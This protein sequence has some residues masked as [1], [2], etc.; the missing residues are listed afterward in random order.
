M[1][2]YL[3]THQ[4][5][6]LGSEAVGVPLF[7]SYRRLSARRRLPVAAAPWALDSGSFT[8]L[9]EVGRW[10]TTEAEYVTAVRRYADEI[11]Q[12]AWAAPMDWMCEP[13]V[14]A[15]TGLTVEQHQ[16]NTVDNYVR[17]RSMAPDLPFI[18]VLQ[19]WTMADY[20]RCVDLYGAAGVDLTAE[21][22]V[23]IGSVCRRQNTGEVADI[24]ARIAGLGVALHGFGVKT[25]GLTHYGSSLASADS[26]AW[27]Y[28]AR[29]SPPLPGC[30]HKSCANCPRFALA[31]RER[32][33]RRLQS[34]QLRFAA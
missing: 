33:L 12:L 21:P 22:L 4:T 15:R 7:V 20:L 23:G 18:P 34:E 30:T 10:E 13:F 16:A 1:M 27:S 3:G 29:R 6:W 11:G 5:S 25:V 9:N 2:F 14:T 28:R 24:M 26:L 31:W 17:L 32:V 8:E 19:G